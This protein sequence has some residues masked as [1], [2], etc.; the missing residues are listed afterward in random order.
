MSGQAVKTVVLGD[1]DVASELGYG[2][3]ALVTA[4]VAGASDRTSSR[5]KTNKI[6]RMSKTERMGWATT[7]P[8]LPDCSQDPLLLPRAL[9]LS[10]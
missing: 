2:H 1:C 5:T 9:R 7:R 3:V 10:R 4:A 8:V 6:S